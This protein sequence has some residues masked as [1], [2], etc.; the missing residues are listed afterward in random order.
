MQKNL[1][2]ERVKVQ[3]IKQLRKCT[4]RLRT[5][6]IGSYWL[7]LKSTQCL[8]DQFLHQVGK[9]MILHTRSPGIRVLH[10][11]RLTSVVSA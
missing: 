4:I 9:F 8:S 10:I 1:K 6:A 11:D 3:K 5:W 7:R 2:P